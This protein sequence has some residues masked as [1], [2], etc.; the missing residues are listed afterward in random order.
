V[1]SLVVRTCIDD[2][3][4]WRRYGLNQRFRC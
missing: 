4:D 3:F 2:C 1:F